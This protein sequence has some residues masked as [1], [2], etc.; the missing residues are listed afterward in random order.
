[1]Q[2]NNNEMMQ[3]YEYR[4]KLI[5][6]I[7][8]YKH[9]KDSSYENML[10][11]SKG[12]D[13]VSAYRTW[14]V[15]DGTIRMGSN[16]L[17]PIN[18]KTDGQTSLKYETLQ[19][20]GNRRD[21][22][23]LF[24]KEFSESMTKWFWEHVNEFREQT[25]DLPN[26]D[27]FVEKKEWSKY[28]Q[29]FNP[30]KVNSIIP[31]SLFEET[32]TTYR[33]D[34][35][36][37][38][39]DNKKWEEQLKHVLN[40]EEVDYMIE[41]LRQ[42]PFI[43][44]EYRANGLLSTNKKSM[45]DINHYHDWNTYNDALNDILL[46]TINLYSIENKE[47]NLIWQVVNK[48]DNI[49]KQKMDKDK[50]LIFQERIKLLLRM[51][52]QFKIITWFNDFGYFNIMIIIKHYSFL[53]NKE[54]Y[55]LVDDF[56]AWTPLDYSKNKYQTIGL[57][58]TKISFYWKDKDNL[59]SDLLLNKRK[60]L[61]LHKQKKIILVEGAFDGLVDL[62]GINLLFTNGVL[63]NSKM[64]LLSLIWDDLK[65]SKPFGIIL[66]ND[67]AGRGIK[68]TMREKQWKYLLREEVRLSSFIREHSLK[69]LFDV[70]MLNKEE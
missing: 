58:G 30:F 63:N 43:K 29:L 38:L 10:A 2:W 18:Y 26:N 61:E 34:L 64:I 51:N 24:T 22:P 37:L 17:K 66:D 31:N 1:M 40:K 60:A 6:E 68:K 13:S 32:E 70:Y 54:G 36:T 9:F 14:K 53:I 35:I 16:Y 4:C 62:N 11:L 48:K 41:V 49:A 39:F 8:D 57:K 46:D 56:I 45:Y 47:S 59:A 65:G 55:T 3:Y 52:Q 7:L 23:F 20:R 69:D 33:Y 12:K 67:E 25:L 28:N 42:F 44:K 50:Y 5:E 15:D 27:D 21:E 19:S